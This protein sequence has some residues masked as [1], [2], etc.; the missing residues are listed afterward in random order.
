[1]TDWLMKKIGY[2]HR[3]HIVKTVLCLTKELVFSP[4]W[5]EETHGKD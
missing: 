5:L 1:M 3:E 2:I 4:S